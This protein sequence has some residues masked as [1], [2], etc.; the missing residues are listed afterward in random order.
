MVP[1][2]RKIGRYDLIKEIGRGNMGVIY[3]GHDSFSDH[4]VAIKICQTE[5][6]SGMDAEMYRKLFFNEIHAAGL[7]THPNIVEMYDAA[8]DDAGYYLV[9]EYIASGET[10]DK[11]CCPDKLLPIEKV[12]EIIFKCATALDY[13]HREGVI[14]RDIK[15]GNILY[16]VDQ[17]KVKISDFGVAR[18]TDMEISQV[19]GTMGTPRYMSPEQ[20]LDEPVTGQTD[21]YSL[22]IVMYELLTGRKAFEGDNISVINNKIVEQDPPDVKEFGPK[23]PEELV[24]IL[25]KAIHKNPE[26]RYKMGLDLA[27]DLSGL[28]VALDMP[29]RLI[30]EDERFCVARQLDFFGDFPDAQIWE[31]VRASMWRRVK[32]GEAIITEG[33]DDE[34][35]YII[36]AG[37]TEVSKRGKTINEMGKGDCFGEVGYVTR[38]VR[39]ASVTAKN[40]VLLISVNTTMLDLASPLCQLYFNRVVMTTLAN[41]VIKLSE[42]LVEQL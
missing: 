15:P 24:A 28:S 25:A 32:P 30:G 4:D 5:M 38:S 16:D 34:Y 6:A 14:H 36:A 42:K 8:F 23:V 37:T 22:G 1:P 27:F 21:I 13:A 33:E 20:V 11:F 29:G 3:L 17:D 9:M 19:S 26:S 39:S 18:V 31:F 2:P 10:L 7:L 12:V 35:F 40:G 41:R